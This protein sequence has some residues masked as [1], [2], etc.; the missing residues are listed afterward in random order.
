MFLYGIPSHHNK[1]KRFNLL[2]VTITDSSI[3]Y[4]KLI[5]VL[6]SQFNKILN[7]YLA[8]WS[9]NSSND[10]KN[11]VRLLSIFP[12]KPL[13][14]TSTKYVSRRR[15]QKSSEDPRNIKLWRY[16]NCFLRGI[17]TASNPW[18][19]PCEIY[20]KSLVKYDTTQNDVTICMVVSNR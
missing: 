2:F 6:G 4:Q 5:S 10:F 13:K 9:R 7:Q 19:N 12:Q 8:C 17:F 18:I 11:Y 16:N 20:V 1:M 3:F 14:K 15:L